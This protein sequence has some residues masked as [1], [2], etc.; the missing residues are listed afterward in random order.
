[1]TTLTLK[2]RELVEISQEKDL[3][4]LLKIKNK[5]VTLSEGS[6]LYPEDSQATHVY[7]IISGTLRAVKT[8]HNGRRQVGAFIFAGEW[9]GYDGREQHFYA[10][11]AITNVR[12]ISFLRKDFRK[13]MYND[14][15]ILNTVYNSLSY[16]LFRAEERLFGLA[17]NSAIE[18]VSKFLVDIMERLGSDRNNMFILPMSR[19]DISDYLCISP[20]TLSRTISQLTRCGIIS[21]NGRYV[22]IINFEQLLNLTYSAKSP[23][24]ILNL[25]GFRPRQPSHEK[26]SQGQLQPRE[27]GFDSRLEVF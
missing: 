5:I 10:V 7:K 22:K 15:L 11:E 19:L 2:P 12:L 14:Q 23:T 21:I 17:S 6:E 24:R 27:S 4:T 9:T 8:M 26:E 18:R 3:S 25:T 20:E 1:M 16:M 13:V